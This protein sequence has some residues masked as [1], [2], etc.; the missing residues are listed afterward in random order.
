MEATRLTLTLKDGTVQCYDS[1]REVHFRDLHD[2]KRPSD[3]SLFI[4]AD[5]PDEEIIYG[6]DQLSSISFSFIEGDR[7]I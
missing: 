7:P 4:Q 6:L 1:V 3:R 5:D 2:G